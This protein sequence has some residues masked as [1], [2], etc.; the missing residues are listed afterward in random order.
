V[1]G[2]WG[3]SGSCIPAW[4]KRWTSESPYSLPNWIS[5]RCWNAAAGVR[6]AV[7]IPS[8][9]RDLALAVPE[10]VASGDLV[11]EA[12][13]VGGELLRE[14]IIFDTYEGKGIESG[15]KGI[16]IGLILR[17]VSRTL[18]DQDADRVVDDVVASLNDRFGVT[19]RG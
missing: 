19:L 5:R 6:R 4:P 8:V 3:A 13:K 18:T 1:T 12:K 15:F 17:D 10:A 7:E 14:C 9:R 16:A 2:A 11:A